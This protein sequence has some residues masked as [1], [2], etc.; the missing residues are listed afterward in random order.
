MGLAAC[1]LDARMQAGERMSN[2]AKAVAKAFRDTTGDP[3]QPQQVIR[4]RERCMERARGVAGGFQ[5]DHPA[6]QAWT[7]YKAE[8]ATRPDRRGGDDPA[9]WSRVAATYEAW[10]GGEEA[11][12]PQDTDSKTSILLSHRSLSS[13]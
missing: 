6:L 4:W 8:I 9:A 11:G 10:F 13:G 1:A 2:A 7:F 5:A 12:K 3:C